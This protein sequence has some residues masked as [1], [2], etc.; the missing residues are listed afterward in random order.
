MVKRLTEYIQDEIDN[1]QKNV[2]PIQDIELDCYS[3]GT[4]SGKRYLPVRVK[5]TL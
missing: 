1:F 5:V 2:A 4:I 3:S